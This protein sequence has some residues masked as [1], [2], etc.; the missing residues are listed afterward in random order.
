[1]GRIA[2]AEGQADVLLEL[3]QLPW[4]LCCCIWQVI[5]RIQ[6]CILPAFRSLNRGVVWPA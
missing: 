4:C 6:A 5:K 3:M 2:W 1:M